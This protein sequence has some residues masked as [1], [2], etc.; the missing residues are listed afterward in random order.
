MSYPQ[1]SYSQ[2]QMSYPQPQQSQQLENSQQLTN[3][4]YP[5]DSHQIIVK[6]PVKNQSYWDGLSGFE[7]SPNGASIEKCFTSELLTDNR[8]NSSNK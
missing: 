8:L 7:N 4:Q 3:T 6:P 5:I 1:R 2:P